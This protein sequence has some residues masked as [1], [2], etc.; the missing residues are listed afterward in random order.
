MHEL[1]DSQRSAISDGMDGEAGPLGAVA[2]AIA[3]RGDGPYFEPSISDNGM[4]GHRWTTQA[5][6]P[7][8]QCAVTRTHL[9]IFLGFI[10]AKCCIRLRR[11]VRHARMYALDTFNRNRKFAQCAERRYHAAL[12]Q[13]ITDQSQVLVQV[14]ESVGKTTADRNLTCYSNQY[15]LHGVRAGPPAPAPINTWHVD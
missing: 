15:R 3:A 4:H 5:M 11:H 12:M 6:T 2:P 8:Y 13:G 14:R 7:R 1:T 10:Q 9:L